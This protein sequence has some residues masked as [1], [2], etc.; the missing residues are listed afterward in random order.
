MLLRVGDE[1][2]DVPMP[3]RRPSRGHHEHVRHPRDAGDRREVA[4]RVVRHLRVQPR[5]DRV[6]RHRAHDDRRAVGRRLRGE[7][8]ADVAAGAGAVV[9]D[10][11]AEAVLHLVGERAGDDVER[12][13]G[14]IGDD[15]ADRLRCAP[16]RAVQRAPR[17]AAAP[18]P[19]SARAPRHG[20]LSRI[21]L[22]QPS[23]REVVD[24]T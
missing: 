15:Q 18:R 10:D 8:G 16:A 2:G 6:R 24:L 20:F 22:T 21:A 1:V 9:D 4:D 7:V 5:V 14:R 3:S 23:P 17:R 11:D 19:P 13:A 12:A